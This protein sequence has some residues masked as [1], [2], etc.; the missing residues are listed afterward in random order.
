M[1][2]G[3]PNDSFNFAA[4]NVIFIVITYFMAGFALLQ[5]ARCGLIFVVIRGL[6]MVGHIRVFW[7]I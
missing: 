3:K 5:S 4:V 7:D 1:S 2:D 6:Y